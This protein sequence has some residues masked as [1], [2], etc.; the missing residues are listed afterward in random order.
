MDLGV[1]CIKLGV[2]CTVKSEYV[3]YFKSKKMKK[4]IDLYA[5]IFLMDMFDV[6]DLLYLKKRKKGC[7][8]AHL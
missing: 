7:Q 3:V 2:H 4:I 1:R 6:H 8:S 5:K